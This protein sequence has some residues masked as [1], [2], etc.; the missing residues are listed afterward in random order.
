MRHL[1][2]GCAAVLL[3]AAGAGAQ[4]A[5]DTVPKTPVPD[6]ASIK[7]AESEAR[8][9]FKAE[10][11]STDP[12]DRRALARKL[13][14]AGG[15]SDIDAAT[16]FAVLRE[17]VDIAAQAE[18]LGTSFAAADRLAGLFEVEPFG[19]KADALASARKAARRTDTL[20]RIAITAV[21]TAREAR[22]A[23]RLESALRALKEAENAAKASKDPALSKSIA[24]E[25]KL[26]AAAK[27]DL[28]DVEE[29]KTRLAGSPD[30]AK[31]NLTLG[32]WL[33]FEKGKMKEGLPR[34]AKG[35]DRRLAEAAKLDLEGFD[36]VRIGEA[37]MKL[38]ADPRLPRTPV[39]GRACEWLRKAWDAEDPLGKE[40]LRA[41]ILALLATGR[42]G[43]PA[44]DSGPAPWTIMGG[45]SKVSWDPTMTW[46]GER[47]VKLNAASTRATDPKAWTGF[48][49][50]VSRP[51]IAGAEYRIS[52]RALTD[53][54]GGGNGVWL[55]F[56]G[57]DGKPIR[58]TSFMF[59]PD[60]PVWTLVE[61]KLEAPQGAD[62]V[63]VSFHHD[64]TS[65]SVWI[66][67]VS[68]TCQ[69]EDILGNG[70]LEPQAR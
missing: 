27:K 31:A 54:A 51:V 61:G 48:Y 13:F 38:A 60:L 16:R 52:V 37:W 22:L 10:Y 28:A 30:D 39:V 40:R 4:D 49:Q 19:L 62:K 59:A 24:D 44:A 26:L 57:A 25:A 36:A 70:D 1:I 14:D 64:S 65:G 33:V 42:T 43:K 11:K 34:L 41:R 7:K 12:A 68:L 5:P 9:L 3:L 63:E 47:S 69:G 21:R 45:Q 15:R 35:A 67:A 2:R 55:I 29:A 17:A 46:S 18:D 58:E 23:D 56:W 50:K 20:A 8:E 6:E 53:Q 32:R 66:D